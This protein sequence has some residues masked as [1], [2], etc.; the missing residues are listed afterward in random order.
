MIIYNYKTG[1]RLAVESRDAFWEK[2]RDKCSQ[3]ERP[4]A[5]GSLEPFPLF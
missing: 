2:S 5:A 3:S 4:I 1:A